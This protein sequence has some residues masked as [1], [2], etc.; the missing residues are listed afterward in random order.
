[1][2]DFDGYRCEFLCVVE[3]VADFEADS[4]YE[5]FEKCTPDFANESSDD[6]QRVAFKHDNRQMTRLRSNSS[7]YGRKI[8]RF[9]LI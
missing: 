2:I 8:R 3:E 9:N 1:M 5:E 4:K 6:F 7:Q